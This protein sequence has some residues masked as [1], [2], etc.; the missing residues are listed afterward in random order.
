MFDDD[1]DDER[2]MV[3]SWLW[4]DTPDGVYYVEKQRD[5]SYQLDVKLCST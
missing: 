2:G 4:V 1:H 3:A 5:A